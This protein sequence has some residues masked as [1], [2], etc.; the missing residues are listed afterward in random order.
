MKQ[1]I[2]PKITNTLEFP[3]PRECAGDAPIAYGGDLS[4]QRLLLAYSM[5]IFPWFNKNDPI[6][7]WC[8]DPRMVLFLD[9]FKVRRSLAK[10]IRNGGFEV[11]LNSAF[12]DVI[13]MCGSVKREGQEGTWITDDMIAAYNHLHKLGFAHSVETYIEG[14]LV[15]GL[16]GI[17]IGGVFFGE[18]MFS[19]YN[20][21]SKVAFAY[22]VDHLKENEF[23]LIDCQMNTSHLESLGAREIPRDEFLDIIGAAVKKERRI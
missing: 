14:N 10:K 20:D 15:G 18:S 8:P 21:A 22:L 13:K 19:Q 7:W 2:I 12:L 9:E 11:K 5:G 6:L 3:N 17:A 16:Y 1:I 4:P 23:E